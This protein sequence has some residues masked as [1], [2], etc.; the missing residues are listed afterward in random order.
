MSAVFITF[1][2]FAAVL[3]VCSFLVWRGKVQLSASS[4]R[5]NHAGVLFAAGTFFASFA[6]VVGVR[7]FL[8]GEDFLPEGAE[9]RGSGRLTGGVGMGDGYLMLRG[10]AVGLWI[11]CSAVFLWMFTQTPNRWSSRMARNAEKKTEQRFVDGVESNR[12]FKKGSKMNENSDSGS[13]QRGGA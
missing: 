9:L 8:G 1:V 2:A 7:V 12:R 11:L 13:T 3:M 10:A 5:L 4:L 6:L